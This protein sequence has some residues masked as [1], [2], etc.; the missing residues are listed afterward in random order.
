LPE[1]AKATG[2]NAATP[3][4][5]GI[6]DSNASLYAH[7]VSRQEPFSVVSTG[8]WVI[9]MAIGGLAVALD[10]A[11]DTLINVNALG[12]PVPSA[13]FMGGR[14]FERMMDGHKQNH[15]Q[16]DIAEV[17]DR[18]IMLLPSIEK[19]SGPFQG[20]EHRWTA[21]ENGLSDGQRFV[22]VSFYLALM[23]ATGL[24][25][26]GAQGVT[27]V[28]GPFAGNAV[29]RAMLSA[30]TSRPAIAVAGTGT[31]IGAALLALPDR[32][33]QA[34]QQTARH[35]SSADMAVYARKWMAKVK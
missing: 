18:G 29:Y 5:C 20:R 3:V 25:M 30:A 19:R 8:T 17:I 15:T 14:E 11:R 32:L 23:T 16:S 2:L 21:D 9:T 27:V 31:S 34:E 33:R 1:L 4:H 24:E 6:H 35:E 26:T 22:A 7:L 28:E 10:P 13:R 12:N